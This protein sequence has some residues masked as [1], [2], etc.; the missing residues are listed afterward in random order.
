MAQKVQVL[1]I[2][3][4]DGSEAT[5]TVA[6]AL[7]GVAYEIDLSSEN[8]H[9]L[10]SELAPYVQ[11]ARRASAADRPRRERVG[12][13]RERS[14]RIRAWAE[15]R[16][17]KVNERGRIP[18]NVVHQ[19][20]AASAGRSQTTYFGNETVP[21]GVGVARGTTG[22]A[23]YQDKI[24]SR[25]A[26]ITIDVYLDTDDETVASA[27]F[28]AVDELAQAVGIENL[29]QKGSWRGSIRERFTGTTRSASSQKKTE[30]RLRSLESHLQSQ[31]VKG[32]N[33]RQ[34]EEDQK[35]SAAFAVVCD[36]IRDVPRACIRIGS[37]VV[38]KYPNDLGESVLIARELTPVERLI[39]EGNPQ[40]QKSPETLFDVLALAQSEQI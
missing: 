22:D 23:G 34:V 5:E 1:L 32:R 6:F 9:K 16:G 37:L 40:L 28:A 19:Y 10:R 4:I 36:T 31:Q 18:A 8:A 20:A 38:V 30:E 25:T 14:A 33:E 2:D 13:G 21:V 17:L 12:V 24:T 11:R 27:V 3:D 29:M 35:I 26:E 15:A 39:F 7:D